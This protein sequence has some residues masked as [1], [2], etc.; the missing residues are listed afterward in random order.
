MEITR[1]QVIR[2]VQTLQPLAQS[3]QALGNVSKKT[4]FL[5]GLKKNMMRLEPEYKAIVET[6]NDVK[7][8]EGFEEYRKKA[9]EI[10][11][12]VTGSDDLSTSPDQL[13]KEK[14]EKL[15]EEFKSLNEEFKDILETQQ[16]INEELMSFLEEKVEFEPWEILVDNIPDEVDIE[17]SHI[18]LL[19]DTEIIP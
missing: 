16:K 12:K 15:Q 2:L 5:Y 6:R 3:V 1:N 7:Q 14:Q 4:K 19:M 11:K 18:D 10:Q 9:V 17:P 8:A 13:P